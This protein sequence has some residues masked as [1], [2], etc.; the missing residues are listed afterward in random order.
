MVLRIE[1]LRDGFERPE[2]LGTEGCR[3]TRLPADEPV[4]QVDVRLAVGGGGVALEEVG[5]GDGEIPGRGRA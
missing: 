5:D 4:G 1:I 3:Y 2:G